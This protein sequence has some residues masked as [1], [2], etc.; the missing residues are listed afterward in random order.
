MK[1]Q[2]VVLLMLLSFLAGIG[3]SAIFFRVVPIQHEYRIKMPDGSFEDDLT[4]YFTGE[5]REE[6]ELKIDAAKEKVAKEHGYETWED[7]YEW[8]VAQEGPEE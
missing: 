8:L 6:M 1:R 4:K 5:S 3:V 2:T 7:Y